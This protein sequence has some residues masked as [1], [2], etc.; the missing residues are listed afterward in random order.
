VTGG[1]RAVGTP[2][3][4]ADGERDM[5]STRR[6]VAGLFA[7][8]AALLLVPAAVAA[9]EVDDVDD[10][11][12]PVYVT[13]LEGALSPVTAN[14][15]L[16]ALDAAERDGAVALLVEVDTPGGLVA[17]MR[18]VVTAF[19]SARVPVITLVA[20]PGARAASAGT[21]IVMSGHLAAM[22]PATSIGAATPVALSGEEAGDKA[23]SALAAEA[24]AIAIERD[25]NVDFARAA[26]EQ[27]LSIPATQAVEEN[28]VDLVADDRL[29]LLVAL[30]G[31]EVTLID[32]RT[33]ELALAGAPIVEREP[34][35]TGALLERLVDPNLTFVLLGLGTLA[36]LV[37]FAVPGIGAG[38]ITGVILLL[39]AGFS[40][41][42]LPT[43]AVGLA[44]L[45]LA[46]AL[47]IAELF[48][49]GTGVLAAGGAVA[50]VLAGIFMFNDVS[51]LA[52]SPT[53]LI[54]VSIVMLAGSVALT[55]S[56]RN[57]QSQ[58]RRL[59]DDQLVERV[60]QVQVANRD[61]GQVLVDGERWH[62]RTDDPPLERGMYVRVLERQGL[63]LLVEP[64]DEEEFT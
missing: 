41:S 62:V 55:V 42:L 37:E 2:R 31:G 53:V 52:V 10:D 1:P 19:L 54:P 24:E 9:D 8:L 40:L 14:Q 33:V 21:L 29:D 45:V 22:A 7:A 61:Q 57:A 34:G 30:D 13:R 35:L 60:V 6:W 64:E 49:P 50:L 17:S 32:G 4:R 48:V 38:G 16:D 25:R 5:G 20:P 46:A 12:A 11:A 43:T 44:L 39:L 27:G 58:P 15:L 18:E 23:V 26:V 36:L 3:V 47:F 56:V 59:D 28:V 51:G 63:T